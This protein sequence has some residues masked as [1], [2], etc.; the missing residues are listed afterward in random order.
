MTVLKW[1]VSVFSIC[2]MLSIVPVDWVIACMVGY[3]Y[4]KVREMCINVVILGV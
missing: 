1:L 4:I 3:H 2:F